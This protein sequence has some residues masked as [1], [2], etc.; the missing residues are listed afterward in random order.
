MLDLLDLER[1]QS[2]CSYIAA[3]VAASRDRFQRSSI[4]RTSLLDMF[5]T[6][7]GVLAKEENQLS[8]L[9]LEHFGARSTVI[10]FPAYVIDR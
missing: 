8:S 7:R 2:P 10:D 6:K 1:S 9:I 5:Q 3:R 4:K